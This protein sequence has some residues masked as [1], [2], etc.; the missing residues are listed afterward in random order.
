MA[1]T[2]CFAASARPGGQG[3]KT[4]VGPRSPNPLKH[5]LLPELDRAFVTLSEDLGQRGLLG[6]TLVCVMSEMGRT[7]TL[8]GDGRGH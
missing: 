2:P 5:E 6:E 4:R 3:S 8:E 7:P 1:E